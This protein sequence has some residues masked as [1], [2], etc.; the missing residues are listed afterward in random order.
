MALL[1]RV[2]LLKQQGLQDAQIVNTLREE[3]N[4]PVDINEAMSQ[5]RIKAEVANEYAQA[6]EM[7]PSV[8]ASNSSEAQF[9]SVPEAARNPNQA[10]NQVPAYSQMY[11]QELPQQAQAQQQVQQQFQAPAQQQAYQDQS[12]AYAQYPDQSQAYGYDASQ[13]GY[14][15][16]VLDLETVKDISRQQIDEALKKLRVEIDALSKMKTEMKFQMTDMQNRLSQVEGIIHEL[17]S[18]VLRKMGEYGEAIAGI[19]KEVQATQNSFAKVI[20]PLFDKKRGVKA[21]ASHQKKTKTQ[22]PYF[23]FHILLLRVHHKYVCRRRQAQMTL[24]G[25]L[26]Y[27]HWRI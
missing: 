16:Q 10:T 2:N 17:Q 20:N 22:N 3:G 5:S 23:S 27:R 6:G 24:T 15:Q 12:Q 25:G 8:M 14:Y 18:A 9:M 21:Q 26:L 11:T 13:Q 1:E 4:S 19:S 7:Q